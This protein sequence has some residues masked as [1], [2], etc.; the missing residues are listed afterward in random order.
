[1]NS[2]KIFLFIVLNC[3]PLLLRAG[4]FPNP[5]SDLPDAIFNRPK[6]AG[7]GGGIGLSRFAFAGSIIYVADGPMGLVIYEAS[8]PERPRQVGA[9]QTDAVALA[10]HVAG[11]HASLMTSAGTVALDVSDPTN[12][13]ALNLPIRAK[14]GIETNN[15]GRLVDVKVPHP[16]SICCP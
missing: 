14:D 1:M 3:A 10:V 9:Y 6:F 13:I 7:G 2:T 16:L 8:D 5:P 4:V 12:P 15:S 11:T